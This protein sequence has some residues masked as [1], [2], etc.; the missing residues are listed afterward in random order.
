THVPAT[1]ARA[2]LLPLLRGDR[3][4]G[5]PYEALFCGRWRRIAHDEHRCGRDDKDEQAVVLEVDVVDDPQERARRVSVRQTSELQADRRVDGE[6]EG[7]E[8]ETRDE[9]R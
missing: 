7:A 6:T 8:Q 4:I 2:G 5:E 1:P 9:R 3:R